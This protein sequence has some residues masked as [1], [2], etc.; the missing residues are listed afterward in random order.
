MSLTKN[1]SLAE[2]TYSSTAAS[3]NIANTPTPAHLLRI[4]R[5]AQV[6][7]IIRDEIG[8]PIS[9]TSGYRNPTVNKLVGG[10]ANSDHANGD[11]SDSAIMGLTAYTYAKKIV[12]PDAPRPAPPR[13]DRPGDPGDEPQRGPRL[14]RA[15]PAR[16]G[17]DPAAR[18]GHALHDGHPAVMA[19]DAIQILPPK[20]KQRAGGQASTPTYNPSNVTLSVPAYR[21]HLTDL[22]SSRGS[23]DSRTP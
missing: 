15:S 6:M 23:N 16:A 13:Q 14:D 11:A 7:Q 22:F 9:I 4:Q 1:F 12:E 17:P 18:T 20:K 21:E 2:F 8:L 19:L 10:V 5:H 3:R